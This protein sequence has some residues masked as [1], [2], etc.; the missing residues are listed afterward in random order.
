LKDIKETSFNGN[1]HL[2]ELRLDHMLLL[3]LNS[4]WFIFSPI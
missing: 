1:V 4:N 2:H 3:T